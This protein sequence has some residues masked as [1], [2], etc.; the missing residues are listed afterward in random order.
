MNQS[1]QKR[2]IQKPSVQKPS[3]QKPSVQKPSVQKRS[4]Q[5]SSVQKKPRTLFSFLKK[6]KWDWKI[7]SIIAVAIIVLFYLL[8]TLFIFFR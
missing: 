6:I 7:Y 8:K 5:N 2:S 3:V 4:A 1:I